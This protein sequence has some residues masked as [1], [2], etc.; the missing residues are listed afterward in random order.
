MFSTTEILDIAVQIEKNA[1]T[2]YRKALEISKDTA[3]KTLL[4]WVRQKN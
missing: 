1:E 2:T 4:E 3:S